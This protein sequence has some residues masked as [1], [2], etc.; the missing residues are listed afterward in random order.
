[1]NRC[2]WGMM[3]C[4][5]GGGRG[6]PVA[7]SFDSY[8]AAMRD[9]W[10]GWWLTWPLSMRVQVGDVFDTSG[11]TL[12]TAG[13]LATRQV[14]F[15]TSA[16]A[17]AAAFTYDSNGSAVV[18]FKLAG[19]IPDGFSALTEADAGALVEFESASAVLVIYSGLT[20]QG[21]SDTYSVAGDL[22]RR[23]WN[24]TWPEELAG[25]TDVVTA[26]GG[27]VLAAAGSG[28]AAEL[29]A[30]AAAGAGPIALVDLAGRV[31]VARSSHVG[32]Q[33]VGSNVTPFYRVVRLKHTW[34]GNIKALYGPR[35]PGRGA[36]PEPVPPLLVEEARDDPDQVLESVPAAEQ[37]TLPAEQEAEPDREAAG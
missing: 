36:A 17:P 18:R 22:V 14:S 11:G 32:L 25:V 12:R 13:D 34:L 21:M 33:W 6:G 37:P 35:A 15:Q 24:G 19:G 20:Q 23:Y 10:E 26:A 3:S 30:A 31:T 8:A 2:S 7:S 1:M 16:P 29:R 27:T 9:A 4:P 5:I 28:A